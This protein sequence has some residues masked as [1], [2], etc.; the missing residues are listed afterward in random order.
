MSFCSGP[1]ESTVTWGRASSD[2]QRMRK[3]KAREVRQKLGISGS[4]QSAALHMTVVCTDPY[5]TLVTTLRGDQKAI[6]AP[7]LGGGPSQKR[8]SAVTLVAF[9]PPLLVECPGS[10]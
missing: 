4:G 6:D 8:G 9:C 1:L 7:V 5:R 10:V 2:C 3:E